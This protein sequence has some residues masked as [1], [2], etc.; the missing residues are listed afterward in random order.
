MAI[1]PV[2]AA[3]VYGGFV[4]VDLA[5]LDREQLVMYGAKEALAMLASEFEAKAKDAPNVIWRDTILGCA[6]IIR[7]R[8]EV[9]TVEFSAKACRTGSGKLH[10]LK[11]RQ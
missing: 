4:E 11:G 6:Q 7:R 1:T 8:E 9:L 3:D 2:N 10:E 5:K